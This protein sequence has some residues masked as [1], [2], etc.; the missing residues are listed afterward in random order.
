M[1]DALFIKILVVGDSGVGKTSILHQYCMQ[2]FEQNVAPTIGLDFSYKVLNDYK[3]RTIRMQLWDIAGQE[4]FHAV[5]KLYIRGALGCLIVADVTSEDSLN[6]ALRWRDVIVENADE[7][8]GET[9]PL[10]LIQN[11][12]DLLEGVGKLES[13]QTTEFVNDFAKKNKFAGAYQ[14]SAKKNKNLNSSIEFLL[15]QILKRGLFNNDNFTGSG[16]TGASG[17]TPTTG[18]T[19][20]DKPAPNQTIKLTSAPAPSKSGDPKKKGCC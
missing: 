14:V 5:S 17:T 2:S 8:A 12:V 18:G 15:E 20:G 7:L 10:L 1:E 19:T 6:S 11:K 13:F 16:A 4:R 9:I 3:G